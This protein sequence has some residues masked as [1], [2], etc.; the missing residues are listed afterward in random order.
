MTW[1]R[2]SAMPANGPRLFTLSALAL[3]T[4]SSLGSSMLFVA[5]VTY[6][7]DIGLAIWV[8]TRPCADSRMREPSCRADRTRTCNLRFWRPLLYQL[9]HRPSAR[10]APPVQNR[11]GFSCSL[12]WIVWPKMGTEK[13]GRFQLPRTSLGHSSRA[14]KLSRPGHSPRYNAQPLRYVA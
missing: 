7:P 6:L 12:L 5:T 1:R 13:L 11:T 14:V 2:N 4:T 3:A 9:S 8:I 10:I